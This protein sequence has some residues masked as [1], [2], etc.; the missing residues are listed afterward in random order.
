MG[1][2]AL[3]RTSDPRIKS[4]SY[5]PHDISN[6]TSN[7]ISNLLHIYAYTLHLC[8]EGATSRI[9]R[10]SV[11]LP[12]KSQIK[13]KIKSIQKFNKKYTPVMAAWNSF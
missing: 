6:D 2:L 12:C 11:L 3:V 9:T 13:I 1:I 4:Y 8:P 10:W 5:A 7:M